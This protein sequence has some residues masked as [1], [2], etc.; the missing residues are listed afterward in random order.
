M[1]LLHDREPGFIG[2]AQQL[3]PA[4][5]FLVVLQAEEFLTQFWYRRLAQTN[6]MIL[7]LSY[8]NERAAAYW[9]TLYLQGTGRSLRTCK[10]PLETQY[11]GSSVY[12][13]SGLYS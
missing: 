5:P 1:N 12:R 6:T 3:V 7:N 10:A 13:G 4:S 8:R 2:G 9:I 11:S